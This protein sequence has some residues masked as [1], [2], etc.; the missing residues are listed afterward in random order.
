MLGRTR[1]LIRR[2]RASAADFAASRRGAVAVIIGAAIIPLVAFVGLATDSARGYLV[3]AKLGQA[4]DAAALAGGRSVFHSY[5]D[6]DINKYFTANFPVGF[7]GSTVDPLDISVT[8]D[9]EEVTVTASAEVPTTFLRV[10]NIDSMTV[11]ATAVVERAIRGMELALVMDN[12]GSMRSGGKMDA[13]KSA[14]ADLI[15]ILYGDRETVPDFWV[16]LVP[17]A[18]MVNMGNQHTDWLEGGT[19]VGFLDNMRTMGTAIGNMDSGGDLEAAFDGYPNQPHSDVARTPDTN[20]GYIGKDWGGGNDRTIIGYRIVGSRDEGFVDNNNPDV[21]VTLQG[22]TDETNWVDLHS[23]TFEDSSFAIAQTYR[24][25]VDTSTAYRYHRIRI[26]RLGGSDNIEIAEAIFY[27][28][29]TDVDW[30]GCVEARESPYDTTDDPPATAPFTA[31]FWPSTAEQYGGADGDNDW[32][33][34][35]AANAAENEGTGPNLGCG[36]PITPL[37]AEKSSVLDAIDEMEPWHR[38]GTMANM[39]LAWG[40][41]TISP[42]WRGLWD[43]AQPTELPLDYGTPLMDKVVILLTDGQNQWYDWPDALP[44]NPNDDDYPDA[45]YTA[46]NRLS[47][48]RLGTASNGTAN[49]ILNTRMASLCTA[50]KAQGIIMYTITFDLGDATTQDLYRDCATSP[51]HYHNSPTNDELTDIFRAIGNELS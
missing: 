7:M 4:V 19:E 36:P 20:P 47:E 17:Y 40:W 28:E 14:A 18:A 11:S 9:G 30:K 24:S 13:M 34:I 37:I 23:D 42:N 31:L 2:W 33:P 10:V 15:D 3:K 6:D 49:G 44:G 46:Y 50:M 5:R 43:G 8:E 38:G 22:S 29:T 48:G 32:P 25:G 1:T 39:G 26:E 16:S 27:Y 51:A 41:R 45:D 12:T 21:T 35:D